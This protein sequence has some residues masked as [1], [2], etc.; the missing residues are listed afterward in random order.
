MNTIV[1][2]SNEI[3]WTI[4]SIALVI[5]VGSI[6]IMSFYIIFKL[7]FNIIFHSNILNHF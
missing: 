1:K 2:K 3:Y 6:L 5:P 7:T 4:L